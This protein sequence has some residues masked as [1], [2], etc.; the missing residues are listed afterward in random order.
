MLVG[1]RINFLT[2]LRVDTINLKARILNC[3]TIHSWLWIYLC[4]G[5]IRKRNYWLCSRF[6]LQKLSL[7]RFLTLTLLMATDKYVRKSRLFKQT[8][9][10]SWVDGA[11]SG[12]LPNISDSDEI[13]SLAHSIDKLSTHWMEVISMC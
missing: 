4:Y 10:E 5:L 9:I 2:M 1:M 6:F 8:K 13:Y 3:H 12:N 11:H 7:N